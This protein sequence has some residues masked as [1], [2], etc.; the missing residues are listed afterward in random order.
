ML[1]RQ[2]HPSFGRQKIRHLRPHGMWGKQHAE[3]MCIG[4]CLFH[5]FLGRWD[6][7]ISVSNQRRTF[8]S[9]YRSRCKVCSTNVICWSRIFIL[10][11]LHRVVSI[12]QGFPVPNTAR[13]ARPKGAF[14]DETW[15]EVGARWRNPCKSQ[16]KT[17]PWPMA[18]H[19]L[20][21][22]WNA[23]DLSFCIFGVFHYFLLR[24]S[25]CF[26]YVVDVRLC[27]VYSV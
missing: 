22:I 3:V 6:S 15:P 18:A 24:I 11:F 14:H 27:I 16:W 13:D 20:D 12:L 7:M 9:Y 1:L 5:N 8:G 4:T 19:D 17:C 23:K 21:R 25:W 2:S 10:I 26:W